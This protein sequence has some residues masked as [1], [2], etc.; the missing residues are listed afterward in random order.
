MNATLTVC[1]NC[2]TRQETTRRYQIPGVGPR[3]LCE[4]CRDALNAMGYWI[5][6]ERGKKVAA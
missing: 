1:S 3:P 6:E 4:P 5:T 2:R